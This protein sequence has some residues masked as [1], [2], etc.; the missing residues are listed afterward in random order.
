MKVGS[1]ECAVVNWKPWHGHLH[2]ATHLSLGASCNDTLISVQ[3]SRKT[4]SKEERRARVKPPHRTS[5]ANNTMGGQTL[6]MAGGREGAG[7]CH[8]VMMFTTGGNQVEGKLLTLFLFWDAQ[9]QTEAAGNTA[10]YLWVTEVLFSITV[11]I[12]QA[13]Q[14][15]L[16]ISFNYLPINEQPKRAILWLTHC[17][18]KSYR[19]VSYQHFTDYYVFED[20]MLFLLLFNWLQISGSL[21]SVCS[22]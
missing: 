17:K 21:S 3:H 7:A 19:W 5:W 14:L 6:R 22:S 15:L 1:A 10:G 4:G 9:R 16:E 12:L 11:R 18:L 13:F 20:S 8:L 2:C